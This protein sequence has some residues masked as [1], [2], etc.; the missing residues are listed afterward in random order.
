[1]ENVDFVI[2][3]KSTM[4]LFTPTDLMSQ[5]LI[6]SYSNVGDSFIHISQTIGWSS[7]GDK[8]MWG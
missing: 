3:Y 7:T 5:I 4:T 6:I 2:D 8:Q 1:M